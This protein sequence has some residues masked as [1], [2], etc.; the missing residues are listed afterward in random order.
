MMNIRPALCAFLFA[1]VIGHAHATGPT[2]GAAPKGDAIS[3]A[4][5]VIKDNFSE[6]RRITR[7]SRAADGAI[8]ARCD[9]TDYLVFTLFNPK[10]GKVHE[11]A[12]NCTA[13]KQLLNISC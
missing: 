2:F 11:V 3:V 13:A 5:R 9:S 4:S 8:R 10:A 6:C 7:A 12:L 1:P